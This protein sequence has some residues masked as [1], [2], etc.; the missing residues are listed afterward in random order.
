MY[1]FI[2]VA[3]PKTDQMR[4][5]RFI[6]T[7]RVSAEHPGAPRGSRR[8][9]AA[10]GSGGSPLP[11]PVRRGSPAWRPLTLLLLPQNTAPLWSSQA[12]ESLA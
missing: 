9:S 3:I 11:S 12:L 2:L 7:L 8:N 1:A 5:P 4:N 6:N 10:L